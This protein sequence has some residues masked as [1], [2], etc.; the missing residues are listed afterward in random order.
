ME[1]KYTCMQ[2]KCYKSVQSKLGITQGTEA[3]SVTD[4]DVITISKKITTLEMKEL[5]ERQRAEHAVRMY[6]QQR[7]ILQDV[8]NRNKDL[9]DKF[10]EV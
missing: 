4:T 8:E 2:I 1:L 7:I 5:N 6:E 10:S 3:A 9:E